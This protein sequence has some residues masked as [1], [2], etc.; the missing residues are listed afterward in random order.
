MASSDINSI[1]FANNLIPTSVSDKIGFYSIETIIK[2]FQNVNLQDLIVLNST[3]R[4][5]SKTTKYCWS[6]NYK[7]LA[8]KCH[9]AKDSY[10]KSYIK[11]HQ[12]EYVSRQMHSLS[13][14]QTE[15]CF[16]SYGE[17]DMKTF[18]AINVANKYTFLPLTVYATDSANG[19]RHDMML[20]FDNAKKSCYW[21][22]GKNRDDYFSFNEHTPKNVI[23]ILFLNVIEKLG[24]TYEASPSWIFKGVLHPYSSIGQL[25]FAL[26]TAWCYLTL[27]SLDHYGTPIEYI[28]SLDNLSEADR[29]HLLYNALI[30]MIIIC[31]YTHTVPKNMQVNLVT[32]T[33]IN[34]TKTT[35]TNQSKDESSKQTTDLTSSTNSSKSTDSPKSTNSMPELP[36]IKEY[37]ELESEPVEIETF[38]KNEN[39][40]LQ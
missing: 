27:I 35:I 30:H 1:K 16:Y 39:C 14:E 23:D 2:R 26:S 6:L 7:T 20:I 18:L 5:I 22:D 37:N 13:D 28:A 17:S 8:L 24:Y 34:T 19:I 25:D 33:K 32:D 12:H 38:T 29:F 15:L 3:T 11:N 21:F 36:K 4:F 31:N 9:I 40:V 10:E